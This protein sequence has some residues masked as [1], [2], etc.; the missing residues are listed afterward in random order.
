MQLAKRAECSSNQMLADHLQTRK[1]PCNQRLQGF[2]RF[3]GVD[4][5]EIQ[6]RE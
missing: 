2:L 3:G 1:N 6:L 4:A 5:I